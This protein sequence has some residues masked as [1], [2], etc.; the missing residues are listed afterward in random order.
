MIVYGR[1]RVG[2]TFLIRQFF[3]YKFDFYVTGVYNQSTEAQLYNFAAALQAYGGQSHPAPKDWF[4][5][6]G[7]LRDHI[8]GL[9][10]KKTLRNKIGAFR[11]ATKN[12]NKALH[13]TFITTC[14][15]KQGMYSGV[16]QSQVTMDDLFAVT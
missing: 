6:F 8:T 2:K 7:Q 3:E 12:E 10:R 1:R 14:G 9:L 11:Y 16:V 5:A 15:V 4:E 13:L